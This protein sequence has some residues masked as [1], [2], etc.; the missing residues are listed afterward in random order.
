MQE[1]ENTVCF[2]AATA[3]FYQENCGGRYAQPV[4][5]IPPGETMSCV[6]LVSEPRIGS[7]DHDVAVRKT[8]SISLQISVRVRFS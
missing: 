3:A 8:T 5:G 1:I 2:I 6:D 4:A 7:I